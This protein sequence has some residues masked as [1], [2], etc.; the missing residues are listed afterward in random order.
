MRGR[1]ATPGSGKLAASAK[2]R[3]KAGFQSHYVVRRDRQ[4]RYEREL[5]LA[6]RKAE[7]VAKD[8]HRFV[9]LLKSSSEN[10][11]KLLNRVLQ[12]SKAESFALAETPF[13]LQQIVDEVLAT[14]RNRS[15]RQN[16]GASI[17]GRSDRAPAVAGRSGSHAAGADEPD[18]Q[19]GEV[20]GTWQRG[21]DGYDQR[22]QR[23]C[24][25]R[26]GRHSGHG[27]WHRTG[28]RRRIFNAYTQASYDTAAKF[29]GSGLGPAITRK[30]LALFGGDAHVASVPG[31]GSR[32]SFSLRLAIPKS[33]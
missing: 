24:G 33:A 7:Q 15:P 29:G 32:F 26:A 30:L 28:S 19:R 20:Y 21:A 14:Y 18:W 10:M 22:T 16:A 5:L 8:K 3:R 12:L 9:R 23:A 17:I 31:Q 25:Y 4:R 27:D 11:L 6:R 13:S 2:R 1:A